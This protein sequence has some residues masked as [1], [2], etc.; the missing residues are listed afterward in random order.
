MRARGFT[1]I[2]LVVTIT[3]TAIVICI[4]T[5]LISGP[6]RAYADQSRRSELVSAADSALLN[7]ARDVRRA[8][9][10]STRVTTT[11]T[12]AALEMLS[13]I[14]AVRYR[15]SGALGSPALEL[16][17]TTPD[18]SFSTL[19]KFTHVTHPFSST[20]RYLS[21]YNIGVSGAD[22]YELANVMTPAGTTIS[23]ADGSNAGED[24]VTMSPAFKFAYGSPAKRI[25]LVEGPITYL[26]DLTEG[27]LRRFSGYSVASS[28]GLRDTTAE[29]AGAG[30]QNALL[31]RNLTACVFTY[32]AGTSQRAGLVTATLTVSKNGE[33]V[34]LLEQVHVENAP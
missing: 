33:L 30:A 19:G 17:L 16:D 27:T 8:L 15:A 3:L 29:L 12:T 9:P 31:A 2:E 5:F 26:C 25:Y 7:V 22:A 20:V 18:G 23:I 13:S 4:T 21:V 6:V 24:V 14:D 34:R 1:I 11:A 28:Q 32:A 10:N